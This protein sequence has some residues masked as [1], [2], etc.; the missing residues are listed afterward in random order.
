M[1]WKFIEIFGQPR[2]FWKCK[3]SPLRR[4][5]PF[6]GAAARQGCAQDSRAPGADIVGDSPHMYVVIS[7]AHESERNE[8]N[9]PRLS[10]WLREVHM[11]T[12]GGGIPKGFGLCDQRHIPLFIAQ[13]IIIND[14]LSGILR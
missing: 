2:N 12:R 9:A 13:L 14:Y 6:D 5:E 7:L 11:Q 10:I 8:T 4:N 1:G 3:L